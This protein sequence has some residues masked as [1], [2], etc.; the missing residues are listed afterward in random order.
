MMIFAQRTLSQFKQSYPHVAIMF[1]IV[2]V[3]SVN[4]IVVKVFKSFL[5]TAFSFNV[6]V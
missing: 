5:C 6:L 4:V 2:R 3:M 1:E